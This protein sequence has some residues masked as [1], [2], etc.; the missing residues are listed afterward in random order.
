MA[1]DVF[2]LGVIFLQLLFYPIPLPLFKVSYTGKLT[3]GTCSFDI[4]GRGKS[5][6]P[7]LVKLL[8]TSLEMV[9]MEKDS[10]PNANSV[11]ELL[12]DTNPRSV[13]F[14]FKLIWRL[15]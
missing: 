5:V 1:S 14:G 10:R 3:T 4:E 15:L 11:L 8:N 2:A 9:Q 12:T 6:P 13:Y 7:E